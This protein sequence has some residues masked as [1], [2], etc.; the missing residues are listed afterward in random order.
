MRNEGYAQNL[1][2]LKHSWQQTLTTGGTEDTGKNFR[3]V[4]W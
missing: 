4:G 3:G 2:R 1:R